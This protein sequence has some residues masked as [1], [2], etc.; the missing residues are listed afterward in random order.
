MGEEVC[1][2]LVNPATPHCPME[3]LACHSQTEEGLLKLLL[4]LG[5]QLLLGLLGRNN[6]RGDGPQVAQFKA[7]NRFY[8]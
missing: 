1:Q 2:R 7:R 8:L 6:G 5:T 4:G 3:N